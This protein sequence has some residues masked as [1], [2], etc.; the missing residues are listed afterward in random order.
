[1]L[2]VSNDESFKESKNV[3]DQLGDRVD[4]P[5]IIIKKQ[6]GDELRNFMSS[7]NEKVVMSIKFSGVK[8]NDVLTI[9]LFMKSDSLKSIHFFKEFERY[10]KKLSN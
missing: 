5:T 3:D 8:K 1:M 10:Y 9:E 4:I 2:L 7:S 6:E